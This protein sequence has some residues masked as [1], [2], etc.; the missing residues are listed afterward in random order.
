MPNAPP[1]SKANVKTQNSTVSRMFY[2]YIVREVFQ[3][4][5]DQ[6]LIDYF[7]KGALAGASKTQMCRTFQRDQGWSDEE[8]DAVLKAV[9]FKKKP[10]RIDYA[11]FN[12]LPFK[13]KAKRIPFPFTQLYYQENFLSQEECDK[14]I[15]FIEDGLT[16]STVADKSD[17]GLVSD[18]RT[19]KTA[20]L[21]YLDDEFYLEIDKK[22]TSYMGIDP[23]LGESL[24]A[25]K[26]EPT[27]YYKEHWD[28]F[29]PMAKE[30][31]VYCEWM[32]QR[33]WTAMAYL[34]DVKSGGETY[35]KF[36]NKSF[37]P[38][39]GMLLLWNNLYK[40]GIPNFKT[41][42]EALP[43][44]SNDKYVITKW[45]RSWSLI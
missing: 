12:D 26:Y 13:Q 19:S 7:V 31:K 17:S 25:Q 37:Q 29:N 28:F 11:Y 18:Y 5:L 24:Q 44:V 42:H 15:D 20:N 4:T 43:P 39:R 6:F 34:N 35:F 41:M 40:N 30:F 33:T 1:K 32:G 27:Q 36:L 9:N 38:K 16:P 23:F 10:K 21:H 14:L 2:Q 8:L 22:I 3:P 45:F